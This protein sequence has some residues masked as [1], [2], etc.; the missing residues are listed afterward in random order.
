MARRRAA[1]TLAPWRS[2]RPRSSP[3]VAAGSRWRPG[4]PL[5]DEYVLW[6]DRRERPRVCFVPTASGDADHYVVRFYRAFAAAGCEPSHLSLFRRD[7]GGGGRGRPARAPA[8][9]GPDLRRRRHRSS[10]CSAP[11]ARTGS[12]TS[13]AEAWRRG[14]VLCGLSAGSLCWF[15]EAVTA[16]HGAPQRVDG[17]RSAAALQLRALRRRAGAARGVPPLRR[18]RDARRLRGRRRRGAALRRAPS[19]ARVVRSRPRP[20]RLPG[21]AATT[22]RSPSGR[23][24]M[25]DLGRDGRRLT[26]RG[27]VTHDP[28]HG[29]RWLHRRAR[30]PRARRARPPA[31][32][33]GR[34][35]AIL[36]LPTASG[37]PREQIARFHAAS[38]TARASPTCSR[39]SAW[40][41]CAARCARSCSPRT[42]IYVGGGSMRNLLAIWRVHGLDRLLREAW[43]RGVVLA[44]L[45]AGAMCWFQGGVTTSAGAPQP[46]PG[47]GLLPGSLSVHATGSPRARRSTAPRCAEGTLRRAGW[48]T[49][50][51][52]CSFRDMSLERVVSARR[53]AVATRIELVDGELRSDARRARSHRAGAALHARRG[54]RAARDALRLAP[55][56]TVHASRP[57]T[58]RR[59]GRGART[60]RRPATSRARD[61]RAR[62][63]AR[64]TGRAARP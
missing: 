51:S 54:T 33:A 30:G 57:A 42:S 5:L 31:R 25:R 2:G 36:F 52:G 12:T 9:A 17:P 11:G 35:R 26:P 16:F 6:L 50:G 7:R 15:A 58:A 14:I 8:G 28:R 1:P 21:R 55:R 39:S 37:D 56:L 62:P 27:R 23:C 24:A 4:N 46:T 13:C 40:P 19:C 53:G 22:A 34:C 60:G 63:G 59:R 20:A 49:T 43:E 10:A 29:R 45:S 44:G 48:P 3:S 18:R 41:S 61:A 47:L 64:G 32:R 38:A